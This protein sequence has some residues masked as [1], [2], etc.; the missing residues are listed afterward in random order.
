MLTWSPRAQKTEVLREVKISVPARLVLGAVLRAALA[1]HSLC[2]PAVK[3]ARHV[4][5]RFSIVLG[6]DGLCFCLALTY[7]PPLPSWGSSVSSS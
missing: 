6:I 1:T 3:T 2:R 7:G 5:V 4:E